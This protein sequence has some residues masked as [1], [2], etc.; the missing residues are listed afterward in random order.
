MSLGGGPSQS[1]NEPASEAV[2]SG[3]H[4][5]IVARDNNRDACSCSPASAEEV[6][7][8]GAPTLW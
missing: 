4:F 6:A 5:T 8:V 7:T 1:L 2:E 3:A